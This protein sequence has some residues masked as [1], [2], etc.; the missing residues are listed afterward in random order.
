MAAEGLDTSWMWHPFFSEERTDTAG[1]F[2]HFRRDF[3]LEIMPSDSFKI[4]IS[5][6]TRYKLYINQE[7]VTFG[8]VKG[9]QNLWFYDEVDIAPYLRHGQNRIGVHVLRFFYATNFATSFPR[10]PSGG[11]YI[12]AV[13]SNVPGGLEINGSILW[14][15]AIDQSTI[16]CVD[17]AED[18]FLHIYEKIDRT[19]AGQLEW[20][21]A[22][23]LPFQNSTGFS[24]T[25]KLSPRLIP[26]MQ[27]KQSHFSTIHNIQSCIP[28]HVWQAN[29]TPSP[30]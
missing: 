12:S 16:L 25:W 9:D 23:L 15:T 1:L 29:L 18:D 14:E 11:V 6:D 8:P 26:Y 4:R 19:V 20:V 13:D 10:L 24:P 22:V 7:L 21:P 5:A 28:R 30:H 17:Q 3:V 2:V 27:R